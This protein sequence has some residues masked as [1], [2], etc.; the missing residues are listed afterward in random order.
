MLL[1][2]LAACSRSSEEPDS[3]LSP[4]TPDPS[5]SWVRSQEDALESLAATLENLEGSESTRAASVRQI[6][7]VETVKMADVAPSTRSGA[8]SDTDDIFYLVSFGEGSGSAILGAD[9]RLPAVLAVLDETVLTPDDLTC[10]E[11]REIETPQDFVLSCL[12]GSAVST[13]AIDPL[14]TPGP[15]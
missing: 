5:P 8:A 13:M 6:R 10:S 7:S 4:N 14:R 1:L 12:V 11:E 9:R 15:R 3:I 2:L